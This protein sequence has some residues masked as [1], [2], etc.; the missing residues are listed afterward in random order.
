M[1]TGKTKE[2]KRKRG[3]RESYISFLKRKLKLPVSLAWNGVS[4]QENMDYKKYLEEAIEDMRIF[5]RKKSEVKV[6]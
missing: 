3:K 4:I 2:R 5:E 6:G 1:K